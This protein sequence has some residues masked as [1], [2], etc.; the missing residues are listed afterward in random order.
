MTAWVRKACGMVMYWHFSSAPSVWS[1]LGS[2]TTSCTSTFGRSLFLPK[3]VAPEPLETT[4]NVSQLRGAG[5]SGALAV[6]SADAGVAPL[7]VID[8]VARFP[9][10]V[11]R[12]KHNDISF[13][14]RAHIQMTQRDYDSEN[15]RGKRGF[16]CKKK[17]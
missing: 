2:R 13:L 10:T 6:G 11:K 1:A 8:A 3:M 9:P 7:A 17:N 14:K 12:D 4:T 15:R 16:C 5:R